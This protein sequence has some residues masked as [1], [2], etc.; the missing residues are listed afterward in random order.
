MRRGCGR[1]TVRTPARGARRGTRHCRGRRRQ[2]LCY[3]RATRNERDVRVTRRAADRRL[4]AAVDDAPAAAA[5][6]G[7]IELVARAARAAGVRAAPPAAVRDAQLGPPLSALGAPGVL[8]LARARV[9][10]AVRRA[11]ARELRAALGAAALRARARL[12]RRQPRMLIRDQSAARAPRGCGGW[13]S[14]EGRRSP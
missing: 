10:R 5:V 3:R 6:R 2:T 4:P 1:S 14:R 7:A 11:R 13:G 9:R 8:A 12:H